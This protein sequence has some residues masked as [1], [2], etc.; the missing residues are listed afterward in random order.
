MAIPC[1]TPIPVKTISFFIKMPLDEADQFLQSPFGMR[2]LHNDADLRIDAGRQHQEA[3]DG[4]AGDQHIAL[5]HGHIGLEILHQLDKLGGGAGMQ[6][7]LVG[8]GY[9]FFNN[10]RHRF[11]EAFSRAETALMCLRPASC[12][13]RAARCRFSVWRTEASLISIGK[14]RPASASTFLSSVIEMA[15]LD[16]GAP[17][18]F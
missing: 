17:E 1:E 11:Y 7:A 8:D 3:H 15:R 10:S 18:Q 9:G 4:R 13:L 5:D 6:P 2:P 16:G 12:P 14:L